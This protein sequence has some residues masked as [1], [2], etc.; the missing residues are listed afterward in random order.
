MSV[1]PSDVGDLV[2][3]YRHFSHE[4]FVDGA[5]EDQAGT[6]WRVVRI[7][8]DSVLMELVEGRYH[9]EYDDSPWKHPGHLVG[10]E[11]SELYWKH[12]PDAPVNQETFDQFRRVEAASP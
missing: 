6:K 10:W 12:F 11:T 9:M 3:Q 2:E 7:I 5:R 8:P 4:G 1:Q